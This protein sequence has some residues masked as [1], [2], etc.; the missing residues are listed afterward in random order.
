MGGL[1][2]IS[3]PINNN[4][5]YALKGYLT[6]SGYNAGIIFKTNIPIEQYI[7]IRVE[8]QSGMT[9]NDIHNFTVVSNIKF[10]DYNFAKHDTRSFGSG[11]SSP[12]YMVLFID[13]D[14]TVSL[15]LSI[16]SNIA[17]GLFIA[18][19]FNRN[20]RNC[21]TGLTVQSV[22]Y[23]MGSHEKEMKIQFKDY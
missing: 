7:P 18:G 3:V 2:D 11:G 4:R 16:K 21:I 5:I 15:F 19:I 23:S 13:D 9:Q 17:N 10:W 6:S 20:L 14:N 12:D 1:I 8:I 22:E